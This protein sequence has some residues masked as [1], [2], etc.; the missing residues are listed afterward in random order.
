MRYLTNFYQL[1]KVVETDET[2]DIELLK[3]KEK[4]YFFEDVILF[5]DELADNGCALL[6]VKMVLLNTRILLHFE[7]S[8]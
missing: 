7:Q 2:I 3:K 6:N 5:E 8:A 1:F 4:I